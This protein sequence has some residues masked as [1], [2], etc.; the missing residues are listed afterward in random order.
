M[1]HRFEYP[2]KSKYCN[3]VLIGPWVQDRDNA[4]LLPPQTYKHSTTY[5]EHFAPK[6]STKISANTVWDKILKAEETCIL[7]ESSKS[8]QPSYFENFTTM[9]DLTYN[10]FPKCFNSHI[11]RKWHLMRG[12][13][14]PSDEYLPTFGNLSKRGILEYKKQQWKCDFGC[15]KRECTSYT[16]QF[17]PPKP[18]D[19]PARV[20]LPLWNSAKLDEINECQ[21][22]LQLKQHGVR[23]C[24]KYEDPSERRKKYCD[25]IIWK[26]SPD[27]AIEDKRR[28]IDT[29]LH[30]GNDQSALQ[31]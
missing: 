25:P 15:N 22:K 8:E 4:I 31:A 18:E 24:E 11:P 27:M 3:K 10:Y 21:I 14:S 28:C 5:T 16:E 13:H 9:Y 12:M 7:C 2:Q 6:Q 26:C 19:Y 29:V 30:N 23:F 20:P 1:E 17:R